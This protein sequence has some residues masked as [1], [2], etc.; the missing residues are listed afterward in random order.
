MSLI[1]WQELFPLLCQDEQLL[2]LRWQQMLKAVKKETSFEKDGLVSGVRFQD[3]VDSIHRKGKLSNINILFCRAQEA[4]WQMAK[5]LGNTQEAEI[6]ARK[7]QDYKQKIMASFWDEEGYLKAGSQDNR[8][9]TFA[10][11]LATLYLISPEQAVKIQDS[12]KAKQMVQNGLLRNFDQP[13]PTDLISKFVKLGKMEDYHNHYSWPWV[14]CMNIIAKLKIA[15]DHYDSH[16]SHRFRTEAL[17]DF[18]RVSEIF[19]DYGFCEILDDET[20]RPVQEN[21][22][23]WFFKVSSYKSSPDFLISATIYLQAMDKLAELKL[24]NIADDKIIIPH[25]KPPLNSQATLL[26]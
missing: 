3:W 4:M 23:L 13:Y 22:N 26:K 12:I 18:I 21:Y 2:N 14:T 5:Q 25:S 10:N 6:F 20:K 16:I 24:I 9:D 8:F 1:A 19:K 7:M 11:I 17:N 15:K